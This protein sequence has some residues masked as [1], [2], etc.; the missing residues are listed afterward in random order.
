MRA[1]VAATGGL[2]FDPGKCGQHARLHIGPLCPKPA[3]SHASLPAS[4][5]H[6]VVLAALQ[7]GVDQDLRASPRVRIKSWLGT[8]IPSVL[9]GCVL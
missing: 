7:E 4:A 2:G 8:E 5:P 3:N 6:L 1:A 9:A